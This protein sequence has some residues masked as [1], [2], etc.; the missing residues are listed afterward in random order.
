MNIKEDIHILSGISPLVFSIIM[1]K[2]THQ[3][4]NVYHIRFTMYTNSS[5]APSV[6]YCKTAK[7]SLGH[8]ST[9]MYFVFINLPEFYR[10]RLKK[11]L[12]CT[13]SGH[14]AK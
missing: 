4:Y 11:V 6:Y 10:I 12:F 9:V 14:F 7:P 8:Y 5:R 13:F 3:I 2:T 1:V